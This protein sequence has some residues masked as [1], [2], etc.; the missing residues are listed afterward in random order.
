MVIENLE[1]SPK[2]S[3]RHPSA[4]WEEGDTHQ[5]V[6]R[7]GTPISAGWEEGDTHQQVGRRGTPISAG[8]EEGEGSKQSRT[9]QWCAV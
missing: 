2:A 1:T 9:V 5:Q 6:G 3:R 4:G 7:R 8:W